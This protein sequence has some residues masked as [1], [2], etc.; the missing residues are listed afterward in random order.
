[1]WGLVCEKHHQECAGCRAATDPAVSH[2]SA[3][4]GTL[5]GVP[6][7]GSLERFLLSADW[8]VV[9]ARC[10]W[11]V[12]AVTGHQKTGMEPGI[13]E[14]LGPLPYQAAIPAKCP[15]DLHIVIELVCRKQFQV[16]P[17]NFCLL[18]GVISSSFW[19]CF[20]VHLRCKWQN[21][22]PFQKQ[23]YNSPRMNI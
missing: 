4:A 11:R 12:P 5:V 20:N 19:G 14:G 23:Q 13:P 9:S 6:G 17:W 3:G 7:S 2:W 15:S 8:L 21:K 18:F 10:N 22:K 1:M 16:V